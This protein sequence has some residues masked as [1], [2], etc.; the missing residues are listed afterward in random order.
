MM[1]TNTPSIKS[2]FSTSDFVGY[3]AHTTLHRSP[4]MSIDSCQ[5]CILLLQTMPAKR[6]AGMRAL[7][8]VAQGQHAQTI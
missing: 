8:H 7:M 2:L 4:F 1:F 6:L 5:S 3:G